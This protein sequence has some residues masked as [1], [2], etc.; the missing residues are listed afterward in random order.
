MKYAVT[1]LRRSSRVRQQREDVKQQH[2]PPKLK[3]VKIAVVADVG[4]IEGVVEG[5]DVVVVVDRA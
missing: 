2:W 5:E 4:L 1:T 3:Q